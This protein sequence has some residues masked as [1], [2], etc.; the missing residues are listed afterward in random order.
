MNMKI[1]ALECEGGKYYIGRT[2]KSAEARLQ[3][4]RSAENTCAFTNQYK[5]FRVIEEVETESPYEEDALTKK[6]MSVYGI[7]NVRGGSYTTLELADWQR[8]ALEHEMAAMADLCF[9]CKERGHFADACPKTSYAAKFNTL[10]EIDKELD[11]MRA[12]LSQVQSLTKKL[13]TLDFLKGIEEEEILYYTEWTREAAKCETRANELRQK[14]NRMDER[15]KRLGPGQAISPESVGIRGPLSLELATLIK[16]HNA[17]IAKTREPSGR[18][19][20]NHK[21]QM[22]ATNAMRCQNAYRGI[23]RDNSLENHHIAYLELVNYTNDLKK[24][25]ATYTNKEEM[26]DQLIQLLK[27]RI[28]AT[29]E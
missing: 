18:D 24:E 27:R 1:Y 8:K 20:D 2:T 5:P 16:D 3:E 14:I 12:T 25:L 26:E 4:H 9:T 11:R 17:L 6:Y 15:F 7:D 22:A 10:D 13:H 19:A 28:T 29:N 23:L 21:F